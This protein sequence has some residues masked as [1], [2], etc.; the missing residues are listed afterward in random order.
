[1]KIVKAKSGLSKAVIIVIFSVVVVSIVTLG[2]IASQNQNSINPPT[3]TPSP[4]GDSTVKTTPNISL[5]ANTTTAKLNEKIRLTAN[6][7]VPITGELALQWAID[8]SD[9]TFQTNETVTN[10][11]SSH[12]FRFERPGTWQFRVY[13]AGDSSYAESYSEIVTVEVTP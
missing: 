5:E 12:N 1:M 13:W 6:L 9:F 8:S 3:V 10:G 2:Y 7:S 4:S 11:V